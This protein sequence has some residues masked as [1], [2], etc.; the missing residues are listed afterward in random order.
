[1]SHAPR[2]VLSTTHHIK[3]EKGER[4]LPASFWELI[5]YLVDLPFNVG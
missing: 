1:M 4:K 3:K 2:A 5:S